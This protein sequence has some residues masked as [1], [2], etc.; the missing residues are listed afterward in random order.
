MTDTAKT[1]TPPVAEKRPHSYTRHGYTIQDPYFWMKD[2]SLTLI[3][4]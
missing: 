2:Q 1:L 3:H 4:I